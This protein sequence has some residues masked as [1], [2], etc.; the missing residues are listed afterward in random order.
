MYVFYIPWICCTGWK[1]LSMCVINWTKSMGGWMN[2]FHKNFT[3][4]KK[5]VDKKKE[6]EQ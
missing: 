5:E 3:L 4:R 6:E 2:Y 1:F